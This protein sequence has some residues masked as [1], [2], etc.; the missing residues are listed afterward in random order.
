MPSCSLRIN[1]LFVSMGIAVSSGKPQFSFAR[2][3]AN[4]AAAA[5][6]S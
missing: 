4:A 2:S 5:G 1:S 6:V 3:F